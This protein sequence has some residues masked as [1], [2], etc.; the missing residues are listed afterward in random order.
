MILSKIYRKTENFQQNKIMKIIMITM[1]ILMT[2]K[3]KK[4]YNLLNMI[5]LLYS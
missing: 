1:K 3:R 5:F 2:N 4:S